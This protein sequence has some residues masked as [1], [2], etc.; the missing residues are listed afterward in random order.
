[1][2]G[3]GARE[4][5]Q[6]FDRLATVQSR[7]SGRR[8]Q[9][10]EFGQIRRILDQRLPSQVAVAGYEHQRLIEVVGNPAGHLAQRA[11]LLRLRHRLALLLGL[12]A[13][14]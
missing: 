4:Q 3:R 2:L 13:L 5:Q 1:M 11:Q 12:L 9:L 7:L 8:Q 6:A 14:R 10:L